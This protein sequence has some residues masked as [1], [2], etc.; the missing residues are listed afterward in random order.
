[1][2]EPPSPRG[3]LVDQTL[4]IMATTINNFS[5]VSEFFRDFAIPCMNGNFAFNAIFDRPDDTFGMGGVNVQSTNYTLLVA[6]ADVSAGAIVE[7]S[8][9][10][11]Q[12]NTY[13][14]RDVIGLDDGAVFQLM[15][16]KSDAV[17]IDSDDSPAP[18]PLPDDPI[19]SRQVSPTR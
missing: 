13:I 18:L 14:V 10:T 5:N 17:L 11:L 9:L 7:G 12:N 19:F 2:F 16:T 1:M 15:L 8:S 4:S 6:A 3:W